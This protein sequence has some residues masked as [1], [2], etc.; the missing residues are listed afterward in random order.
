VG[1]ADFADHLRG[2]MQ[3]GQRLV[4]ALDAKLRPIAHGQ[5]L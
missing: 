5:Q 3:K 4:V 1:D 2:E